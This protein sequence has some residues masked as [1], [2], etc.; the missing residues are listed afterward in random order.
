MTNP[1]RL[2]TALASMVGTAT[3]QG[4][5]A[6]PDPGLTSCPPGLVGC[7]GG[8]SNIIL[9]NVPDLAQL[10]LL[11]ASGSAVL[12]IVVAGFQMVTSM[13]DDSKLSEQK[14]A[15]MY[16]LGGLVVAILSQF[17]VSLIASEP[18]LA[19]IPTDASA[20][21]EIIKLAVSAVMSIFNTTLAIA[22]VYSGFRMVYAMGKSDEY[23]AARKTIFWCVIGAIVANLANALVQAIAFIFGV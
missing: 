7:G 19:A 20:P 3:A 9:R 6:L 2:L 12:F 8:A 18:R 15:V 10:L 1:V 5:D 13:G 4:F 14:K 21:I 11:V 16:A 17:A 22:I 23:N